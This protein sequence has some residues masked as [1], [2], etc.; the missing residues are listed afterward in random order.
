MPA[1]TP[2]PAPATFAA[3]R[4]ASPSG[5]G[6]DAAGWGRLLGSRLLPSGRADFGREEEALCPA[7]RVR[8]PV[9]PVAFAPVP[10]ARPFAAP[11]PLELA[12]LSLRRPGRERGRFPITPGSSVTVV[13]YERGLTILCASC[14]EI[15][16]FARE[17][18]ELRVYSCTRYE[19]AR[20]AP[21]T[22][23]TRVE[24]HVD[25]QI[26]SAY[27]GATWSDGAVRG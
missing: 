26:R 15:R 10:P 17:R 9:A 25:R 16:C 7:F 4:T 23:A 18:P 6:P 11:P 27:T 19:V 13:E 1:A 14:P 2:R 8:A 20:G 5:S 22:R 3:T 24:K 12:R 21:S